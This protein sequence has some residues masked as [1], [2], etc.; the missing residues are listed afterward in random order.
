MSKVVE[1]PSQQHDGYLYRVALRGWRMEAR[2]VD[3][4]GIQAGQVEVLYAWDIRWWA[5]QQIRFLRAVI[6]VVGGQ[7]E[8]P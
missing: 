5:I 1:F 7:S 6:R 8:C 3:A 4:A 2:E